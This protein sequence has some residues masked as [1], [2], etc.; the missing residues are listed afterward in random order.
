MCCIL[1]ASADLLEHLCE[2]QL[3]MDRILPIVHCDMFYRYFLRI[4]LPP[5]PDCPDNL[6]LCSS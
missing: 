1:K 4:K 6:Y 3:T 5:Y 2:Q